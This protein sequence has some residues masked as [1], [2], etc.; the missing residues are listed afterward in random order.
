[1]LLIYIV[2]VCVYCSAIKYRMNWIAVLD[3]YLCFLLPFLKCTYFL[4]ALVVKYCSHVDMAQWL[5]SH[6]SNEM[7]FNIVKFTRYLRRHA[8]FIL[9]RTSDTNVHSHNRNLEIF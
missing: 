3:S 9:I 7:H 6:I 2:C 4:V 1:M 8:C 5:E